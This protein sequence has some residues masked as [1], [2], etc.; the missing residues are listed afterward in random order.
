MVFSGV[1][2]WSTSPRVDEVHR[3]EDRDSDHGQHEGE[4]HGVAPL[5]VAASEQL[6]CVLEH[7]AGHIPDRAGGRAD[8]LRLR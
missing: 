4:H 8:R 5:S 2:A 1:V 3:S 6:G 7:A